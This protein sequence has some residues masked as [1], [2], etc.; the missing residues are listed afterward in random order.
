MPSTQ[1]CFPGLRRLLSLASRAPL[2]CL[3][4]PPVGSTLHPCW[5]S[6]AAAMKV[7]RSERRHVLPRTIGIFSGAI[8]VYLADARRSIPKTA[9]YSVPDRESSQTAGKRLWIAEPCIRSTRLPPES[10]PAIAPAS[11]NIQAARPPRH[12]T[13][14][15]TTY[16]G[17]SNGPCGTESRHPPIADQ[18]TPVAHHTRWPRSLFCR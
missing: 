10:R 4:N 15:C 17:V 13:A 18:C 2:P 3:P 1:A 6:H 7:L 14:R 12:S 8:L 11:A 9:L 5:P 16:R